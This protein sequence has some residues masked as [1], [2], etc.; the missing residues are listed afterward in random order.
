MKPPAIF[1]VGL[2]GVAP[3]L[4][5]LAAVFAQRKRVVSPELLERERAH[6]HAIPERRRVRELAVLGRALLDWVRALLARG[7]DVR[8]PA[9]VRR[10]VQRLV[11]RFDRVSERGWVRLLGRR[12]EGVRI[13]ERECNE[14]LA[15]PVRAAGRVVVLRHIVI[16]VAVSDREGAVCMVCTRLTSPKSQVAELE[17][18]NSTPCERSRKLDIGECESTPK[19]RH[20]STVGQAPTKCDRPA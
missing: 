3:D 19:G 2:P 5:D 6:G 17:A 20:G 4:P 16:W 18:F 12:P 9:E 14:G 10:D 13:W 8:V 7:E 11:E 1:D 15:E